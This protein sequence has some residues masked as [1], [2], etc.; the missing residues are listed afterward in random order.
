VSRRATL[1]DFPIGCTVRVAR[2]PRHAWPHTHRYRGAIGVVTDHVI[3]DR[4]RWVD[5]LFP[6]R[7]TA[8]VFRPWWLERGRADWMPERN[9]EVVK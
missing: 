7:R 8:L 1:A 5:V 9:A 2:L 6:G 4:D 3:D